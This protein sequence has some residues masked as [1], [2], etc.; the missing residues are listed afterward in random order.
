MIILRQ[1][2]TYLDDQ[3]CGSFRECEGRSATS[4]GMIVIFSTIGAAVLITICGIYT[5]RR[6]LRNNN[7]TQASSSLPHDNEGLPP[8]FYLLTNSSM[9]EGDSREQFSNISPPYTTFLDTEE[10]PPSYN[11]V[12]ASLTTQNQD[13]V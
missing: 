11:A 5:R 2:C 9:S 12:V 1:I 8:P 4:L 13:K 7:N 10:P 6:W 3:T